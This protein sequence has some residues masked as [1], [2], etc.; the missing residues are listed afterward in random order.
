MKKVTFLERIPPGINS[1]A[2]VANILNQHK[3]EGKTNWRFTNHKIKFSDE[4]YPVDWFYAVQIAMELMNTSVPP[5]TLPGAERFYKFLCSRA[6]NAKSTVHH[7]ITLDT[8]YDI[9]YCKLYKVFADGKKIGEYKT[10]GSKSPGKHYVREYSG[11]LPGESSSS[12]KQM[13]LCWDNRHF[14]SG[15][16]HDSE[17]SPG[18]MVKTKWKRQDGWT[19]IPFP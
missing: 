9:D 13:S 17:I 14:V 4:Q 11:I 2:D 8:S 15:S 10:F 19:E 1:E 7:P 3:Y 6:G 18:R 12:P 16:F 5:T